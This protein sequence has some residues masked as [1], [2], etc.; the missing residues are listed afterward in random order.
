[1]FSGTFSDGKLSVRRC[2][3]KGSFA[4]RV[5]TTFRGELAFFAVLSRETGKTPGRLVRSAGFGGVRAHAEPQKRPYL[6]RLRSTSGMLDPGLHSSV[7]KQKNE[8]HVVVEKLG[9]SCYFL[10]EINFVRKP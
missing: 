4:G 6:R 8:G 2:G 9:R 3:E 10:V 5:D 7:K 1:M